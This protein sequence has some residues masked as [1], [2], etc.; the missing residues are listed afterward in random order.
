MDA[1]KLPND[2]R[3]RSCFRLF[4][5]KEGQFDVDKVILTNRL[6]TFSINCIVMLYM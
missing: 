3:S 1:E 2:Q 5:S 6:K 4:S